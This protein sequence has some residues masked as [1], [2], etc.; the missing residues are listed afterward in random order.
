MLLISLLKNPNL[1]GY[2]SIMATYVLIYSLAFP[3]VLYFTQS[4]KVTA[5]YMIEFR[6]KKCISNVIESFEESNANILFVYNTK[7]NT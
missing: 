6:I 5:K 2:K 4:T 1:C 7:P 3:C